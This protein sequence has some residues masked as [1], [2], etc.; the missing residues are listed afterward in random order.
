MFFSTMHF[1]APSRSVKDN[2]LDEA[3]VA[4]LGGDSL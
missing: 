3:F 1:C 4:I 2:R